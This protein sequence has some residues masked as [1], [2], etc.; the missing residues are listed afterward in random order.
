VKDKISILKIDIQDEEAVRKATTG[1]DYIVHLAAQK[2]VD[3]SIKF[4][5]V[6]AKQNIFSIVCLLEGARIN[7]VK[8]VIFV[9]SAAVY[10]YNQNFPL[11]ETESVDPRS[12]YALEKIIGEQY[13]RLYYQLYGV[14]SVA[15]RLF[16]VY[17]PRQYSS[18]THCG[19]VT[20][21]MNELRNSKVASILGDGEQT[22]DMVYVGDVVTA[23]LKSISCKTPLKGQV[24]NVCTGTKVT[25]K[26]MIQIMAETMGL[27]NDFQFNELVFTEGNVVHS[28]G[29]PT[30]AKQEIG[31][32][33]QV[34]LQQGIIE[35]WNWF[36]HNLNYYMNDEPTSQ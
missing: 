8:R 2:S 27:G 24:M 9:S 36:Q 33:A 23:I 29:D 30:L 4:P 25:I 3:M 22:R 32:E 10:G 21:V 26:G 34:S 15:L 6:S 5:L 17:G 11:S 1:M 7:K 28:Q 19:G 20:I 31:F 13:L 18:S 12:P 16:N 35:T 14:D